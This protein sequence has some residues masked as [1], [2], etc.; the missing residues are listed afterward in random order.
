VGILGNTKERK[1]QVYFRDDNKF[2]FV[3]RPLEF[4]CLIEK[5]GEKM[6]RAWKHFYCNQ[7]FFGGYKK[8]SADVVTLGFARDIILDPFDKIPK[9]ESVSE[10][11]VAKDAKGIK[12]WLAKIAEN[13]RHT[14]RS[15]SKKSGHEDLINWALV[16]VLTI[17]TI[18]W[19]ITFLVD[20]L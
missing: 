13:Q 6:V 14:Y 8:M 18:A 15:Q 11:P 19:V 12:N 2:K 9:G 7:F 1:T 17:M 4:S 20:M 5:S 10:K 3:K 16:G